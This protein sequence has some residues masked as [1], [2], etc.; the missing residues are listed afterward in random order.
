MEPFVNLHESVLGEDTVFG[1]TM[2][3]QYF[4]VLD[5]DEA[6]NILRRHGALWSRRSLVD[7][8]DG[9]ILLALGFGDK[10][11]TLPRVFADHL[12]QEFDKLRVLP[13][14]IGGDVVRTAEEF[15]H[16]RFGAKAKLSPLVVRHRR[17]II[18]SLAVLIG[19]DDIDESFVVM[20][21]VF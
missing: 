13:E 4:A 5:F 17:N 6:D 11:G 21:H 14:V 16:N 2:I 20:S 10:S 8:E 19:I 1:E 12:P 18:E 7:D 3:L 15:P 9:S